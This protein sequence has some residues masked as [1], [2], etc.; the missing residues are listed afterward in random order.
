MSELRRL[1]DGESDELALALLRSADDD[2]PSTDSLQ[3]AA[4]VLGLGTSLGGGTALL[5]TGVKG[6]A[7]PGVV[8]HATLGVS[9]AAATGASITLGAVAKQVA[10][11]LVGGLFAMGGVQLAIDRASDPKP[12]AALQQPA[13]LAARSASQSHRREGAS[14]ALPPSAEPL[15]VAGQENPSAQPK[16]N[17]P[18]AGPVMRRR[19]ATRSAGEAVSEPAEAV[20]AK[21]AAT[22][23]PQ[24]AEVVKP[25]TA[26]AQNKSLAA[27][28]ALLDRA[29]SAL[30][31]QDASLAS[32]ALDQYRKER[33]TAI[34]EPEATVLQ[35]QVLEKLGERA[36]AARLARQFIA[37]HPE[38]RHVDS[39]RVLAAEAR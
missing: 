22:V 34:L 4:L 11:G 28:V 27:E 19:P 15:V 36:A 35:I 8:S 20:P 33:Q 37:S 26:V 21:A 38:S 12:I 30:R 31:A 32:R 2:S 18:V 3:A 39:L 24:A 23:E 1:V 14:S 5:A 16:A 9:P 7:G 13:N 25:Q 29:R 10:L 17:S 6:A